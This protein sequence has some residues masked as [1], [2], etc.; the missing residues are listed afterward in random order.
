MKRRTL[1]VGL[2][3]AHREPGWSHSEKPDSVPM[4]RLRGRWLERAGFAN[5][6][7]MTVDVLLGTLS[8]TLTGRAPKTHYSVPEAQQVLGALS[9]KLA[10]IVAGLN[11]VYDG[12]PQPALHDGSLEEELAPDLAVEILGAIECVVGDYLTA[13]IDALA[14]VAKLTKEELERE[15]WRERARMETIRQ[16]PTGAVPSDQ[17][18][19]VLPPVSA[20]AEP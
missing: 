11:E 13:A 14:A 17:L 18:E 19:L 12:L 8:L 15:L 1:T 3:S 5:G 7:K 20:V 10:A 16:F 4:I 9:E 6:T 2:Y